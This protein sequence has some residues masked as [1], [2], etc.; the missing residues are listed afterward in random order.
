MFYYIKSII[1]KNR[2]AVFI[3]CPV[4]KCDT[5][6]DWNTC[7][8]IA[9]MDETEITRYNAIRASRE[10]DIVVVQKGCPH[11]G[12]PTKRPE[13]VKNFRVTCTS[14]K[15]GDWCF[16][17]EQP[18]KGSG[19]SMCG[20]QNC[21]LVSGI[22]EILQCC[23]MKKVS[24]LHCKI[25]QFRACPTCLA[26]IEHIDRCKHMDCQAR[27]CKTAFCFICLAVKK[28]GKWPKECNEGVD[29]PGTAHNYQCQLAPRQYFV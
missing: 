17:C 1:E 20:N 14:C 7:L 5:E 21:T 9:D 3:M 22:N 16:G 11:C 2:N 4:P 10:K 6:W 27:N 8:R 23:Q 26:P 13:E 15:K 28:D 24:Y 18:W 19:S 12:E 29:Q 25:P